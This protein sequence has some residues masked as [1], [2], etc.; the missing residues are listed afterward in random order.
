[1]LD[2]HAYENNNKIAARQFFSH[3]KVFT[4]QENGSLDEMDVNPASI[5][6][7]SSSEN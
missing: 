2:D 3:D 4:G 7:T 6:N 1:M 5:S